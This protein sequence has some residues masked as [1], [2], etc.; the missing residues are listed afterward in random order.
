MPESPDTAAPLQKIIL[1]PNCNCRDGVAVE[2]I[3][4]AVPGDTRLKPSCPPKELLLTGAWK[5]VW[6]NT[7]KASTRSCRLNESEIRESRIF[8]MSD[9]STLTRRGPM[10]WLRRSLPWTFKHSTWPLV[11]VVPPWL[12]SGAI[13]ELVA[14]VGNTKQFELNNAAFHSVLVSYQISGA[15]PASDRSAFEELGQRLLGQNKECG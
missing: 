12:Q 3:S 5:F 4:P 11:G 13:G 15:F 10:R 1:A 9:R 2:F 7:L 14:T 8:L 6:L